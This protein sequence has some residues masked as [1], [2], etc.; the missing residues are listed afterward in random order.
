MPARRRRA[1]AAPATRP[2]RIAP[3][4]V[5][6]IVEAAGDSPKSWDAA[7]IAAVNK[8][9]VRRPV[10]VEVLRMWATWDRTKPSRY[11]VTVKIAYRQSLK[12]AR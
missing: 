7:V 1:S 3:A 5:V 11:H 10:G 8:S 12:P 9:D 2:S 6:R 4:S